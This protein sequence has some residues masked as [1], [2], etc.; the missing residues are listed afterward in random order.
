MQRVEDKQFFS[1]EGNIG[2]GKST[3]LDFVEAN[4]GDV[5][6]VQREPIDKWLEVGGKYHLFANFYTNPEKYSEIFQTHV[7]ITMLRNYLFET[8]KPIIFMERSLSSTVHCFAKILLEKK[9]I[10]DEWYSVLESNFD[11]FQFEPVETF[12]LQITNIPTLYRRISERCR[13]GEANLISIEYLTR[14]NV[15]YDDL[16]LNKDRVSVI[17]AE[18]EFDVL[19]EKFYVPILNR[20]TMFDYP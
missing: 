5:C 11:Q 17:P 14:L 7:F 12:Y 10:S 20:V 13:P 19:K 9:M 2:C 18:E 6:H 16:F 3:F 15:A 1:V 4:Y 8:E